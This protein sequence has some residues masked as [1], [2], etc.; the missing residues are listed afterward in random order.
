M[1]RIGASSATYR[2]LYAQVAR[3]VIQTYDMRHF[4]MLGAVNGDAQLSNSRTLLEAMASGPTRSSRK[5]S[6]YGRGSADREEAGAG[7]PGPW[8]EGAREVRAPVRSCRP[9]VSVI[10]GLAWW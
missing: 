3:M 2:K 7:S 8:G 4:R 9:S 6:T 5:G 10:V 1:V